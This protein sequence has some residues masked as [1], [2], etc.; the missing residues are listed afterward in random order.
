M[1]ALIKYYWENNKQFIIDNSYLNCHVKGLHSIVLAKNNDKLIRLYITEY[2][3][4]L[5]R[6]D[7][8]GIT[9]GFH[10]H[11]CDLTLI[12]LKGTIY[13]LNLKLGHE[14]NRPLSKYEYTSKITKGES[15]F[16][17]IPE[18]F[19][20]YDIYRQILKK[21]DS[22]HL[23]ADTIHTIF[24]KENKSRCAWLVLEGK[25]DENYKSIIYTKQ[26]LL[27]LD[28]SNLY[29]KPTEDRI[30]GLLQQLM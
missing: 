4:D 24:L 11:H 14:D 29:I 9:L 25:E 15:N 6:N 20:F 17:L 1:K 19:Q 7:E 21:G 30:Y 26:N 23:K 27:K 12:V 28:T 16:K 3:N 10:A 18:I 22:I 2:D 13:N 8:T 5:I